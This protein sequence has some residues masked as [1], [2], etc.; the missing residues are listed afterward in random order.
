MA[1]TFTY[2]MMNAKGETL[3]GVIIAANERSVAVYIREKGNY[4]TEIKEQKKAWTAIVSSLFY[5]LSLKD[6]AL[7][8]RQFAT[9][10]EAGIAI[11][12]IL[13]VLIEQE[14]K[15]KLKTVFADIYLG[16]QRGEALSAAL[17]ARAEVFPPFMA[18]MIFAAEE[19][20]TLDLMLSRLAL[21]FE[22]EHKFRRKIY[23]AMFY[24]LFIALF[25]AAA[26][27]F[28][29]VF[30]LPP[31]ASFLTTM[32]IELPFLT[33]VLLEASSFVQA[34]Y[35]KLLVAALGILYLA[36][37]FLKYPQARRLREKLLLSLPVF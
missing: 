37:I 21:H 22:K 13:R 3:S 12:D 26:V 27:A 14:K 16:V 9:M 15:Q 11:T 34:H 8:C 4:V 19:G 23:A 2:K 31:L 35:L 5:S 7:F 29:L 28:L 36:G 10:A 25:S 20:G 1:K 24:P 18:S 33:L 30:A 17:T 32:N 6:L